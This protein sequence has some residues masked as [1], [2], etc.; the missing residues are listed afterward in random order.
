M[1]ATRKNWSSC[2]KTGSGRRRCACREPPGRENDMTLRTFF[3]PIKWLAALGLLAGLLG[4]AYWV[5][6]RMEERARRANE[7][8]EQPKRIENNQ[9]KLSAELA[10]SHLIETSAAESSPWYERVTVYG[11]VVPNPRAAFEVRSPFAGTL[12]VEAGKPWKVPG[13]RVRAG[14]PLGWLDIR[15]GPTER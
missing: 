14:Q 12:R 2:G 1:T 3:A 8:A 9:I 5:H 6:G 4:L 15:V 7:R 11:R 10:E 13:E